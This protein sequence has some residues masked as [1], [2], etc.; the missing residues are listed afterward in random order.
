MVCPARALFWDVFPYLSGLWRMPSR[1]GEH[2]R[3]H[4]RRFIGGESE[5]PHLMKVGDTLAGSGSGL[6][7]SVRSPGSLTGFRT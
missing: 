4:I 2:N 7:C 5:G 3:E 1:S 6:S